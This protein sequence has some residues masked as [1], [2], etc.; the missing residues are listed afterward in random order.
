MNHIRACQHSKRLTFKRRVRKFNF[1]VVIMAT[2]APVGTTTSTHQKKRKADDGGSSVAASATANSKSDTSVA[3]EKVKRARKKASAATVFCCAQCKRDCLEL[4]IPTRLIDLPRRKRDQTAVVKQSQISVFKVVSGPCE[5]IKRPKG[6]EKQYIF[7]CVHCGAELGYRSKPLT[8]ESKLTYF[9]KRSIL[10]SK[11]MTLSHKS[12]IITEQ[13]CSFLKVML[14]PESTRAK[15]TAVDAEG[16][17]WVSVKEP[18]YRGRANGAM[19]A[20][21][22]VTLGVRTSALI[23]T[24]GR[25]DCTK[26]IQVIGVKKEWALKR[27]RKATERPEWSCQRDD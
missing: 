20:L 19:M 11:T 10:S 17:V 24:E 8:E 12:A 9:R 23:I 27:L 2:A 4:H 7:K 13:D 21:L 16:V 22:S 5:R 3:G 14:S 18:A 1:S 26:T 25:N 15:I 6:I